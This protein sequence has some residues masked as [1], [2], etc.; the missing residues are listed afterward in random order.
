MKKFTK[1]FDKMNEGGG[2]STLLNSRAL[3]DVRIVRKQQRF[4]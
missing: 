1:V 4:Q 2:I 3:P